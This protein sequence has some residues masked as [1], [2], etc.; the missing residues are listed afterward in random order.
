MF[1]QTNE[2]SKTNLNFCIPIRYKIIFFFLYR[3]SRFHIGMLPATGYTITALHVF[4]IVMQ[5]LQPKRCGTE[6]GDETAFHHVF[7]WTKEKANGTFHWEQT[8]QTGKFQAF[9][10]IYL[11]LHFLTQSWFATGL[12]TRVKWL[13]P[14]IIFELF[15][16]TVIC[17]NYFSLAF[18]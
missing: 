1:Q 11:Y 9:G 18:C 7:E 6:L 10:W 14:G 17:Y 2:K 3:M 5:I 8:T 12:T 16:F 15:V 4:R 13:T